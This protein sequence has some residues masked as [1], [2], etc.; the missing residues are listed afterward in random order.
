MARLVIK[1]H[2]PW[3]MAVAIITLSMVLSLVTWLLLDNNH[4]QVIHRQLSGNSSASQ[5][6]EENQSLITENTDLKGKILMLEQTSRLDQETAVQMQ[7]D[8]MVLQDEIYGLKRELEFYKGIMDTSKR[9]SGFDIHGVFINPLNKPNHFNI[10]VVLTNVDRSDRILEGVLDISVDGIQNNR[11]ESLKLSNMITNGSPDL[12][13]QLKNF[14][15]MD[16]NVELPSEFE[17]ERI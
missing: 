6:I 17:P 4:W 1:N 15:Q 3:Q 7:N 14:R 13:F 5:L 10:K 2:R 12:S 16:V 9:V 8:L 11:K